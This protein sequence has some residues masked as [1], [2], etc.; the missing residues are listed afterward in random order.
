MQVV[1]RRLERAVEESSGFIINSR[2]SGNDNY[3]SPRSSSSARVSFSTVSSKPAMLEAERARE[4]INIIESR[5]LAF[6]L[7]T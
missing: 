4:D 1:E 5:L 2:V 7:I 6:A 3:H